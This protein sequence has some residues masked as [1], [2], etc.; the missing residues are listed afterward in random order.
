MIW[1]LYLNQAQTKEICQPLQ[2]VVGS[3]G[4]FVGDGIKDV[5]TALHV[6]VTF[7]SCKISPC[8]GKKLSIAEIAELD[9]STK[10]E[11]MK[12][13]IAQVRKNA[14][15]IDELQ[16]CNKEKDEIIQK[17]EWMLDIPE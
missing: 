5:T 13:L 4:Y 9:P 3:L 16:K 11:L 8:Q 17:L 2:I 15:W 1:V 6:F 7:Y 10:E 14:L 12:Q